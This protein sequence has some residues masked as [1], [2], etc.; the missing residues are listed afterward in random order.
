MPVTAIRASMSPI[1]V[2]DWMTNVPLYG[3]STVRERLSK[4]TFGQNLTQSALDA[5]GFRQ[6]DKA[7][8]WY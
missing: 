5:D 8:D 6:N 3:V 4:F 7:W 1:R 2:Q